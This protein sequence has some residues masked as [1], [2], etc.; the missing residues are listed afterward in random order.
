MS[1]VCI[2][3]CYKLSF[4]FVTRTI[5]V[6][7]FLY[8]F[9]RTACLAC[10]VCYSAKSKFH[11]HSTSQVRTKADLNIL[12]PGIGARHITPTSQRKSGRIPQIQ[13]SNLK[14]RTSKP[15]RTSKLTS[16][17][18]TTIDPI[19]Y[20]T[21]KRTISLQTIR[22][23]IPRRTIRGPIPCRGCGRT[24]PL[25]G[26]SGITGSPEICRSTRSAKSARSLAATD[27]A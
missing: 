27:P 14:L 25:P 18:R 9:I 26:S 8:L 11:K 10:F 23:P 19:P 22:D 7:I 12:G 5:Y 1:L 16:S 6:T 3:I 21:S 4:S 2:C 15:T 17:F 13:K 24:T 20:R